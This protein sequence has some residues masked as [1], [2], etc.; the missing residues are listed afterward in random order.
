MSDPGDLVPTTTR[1]RSDFASASVPQYA[2]LG[3][4]AVA[5]VILAL[6]FVNWSTST[7][8]EVVAS[9]LT[10]EQ[11]AE[12]GEQLGSAGIDHRFANGGSAVEVPT[13][14]GDDARV[15]LGDLATP[16]GGVEGYELLDEQGFMI[17]SFRQKIDYQ[18]AVE[19]ELTRT[20]LSMDDVTSAAVHLAV[21][22]QR[23][24]ADEQD[25]TRASV[26]VGGPVT[27]STV[28]S[29]ANVVASAVP[30]LDPANVTVADTSGRILSGGN[31]TGFSR[32]QQLRM[33]EVFEAQLEVAAESMLSVALGPGRA[34]VRV[35]A[36]LD[37]DELES[38]VVTYETE[39]QVTLREQRLDEAF[40]GDNT[41]PLGTLGTAEDVTDAGELAGDSGSAYLRQEVN[42]EFGVPTT[43]TVSRQA[44]GEV[45]R[46]SVAVIV[47][48]TLD[49]PP[50]T[51][52]LEPLVAAAVG[53]DP[54]RGDSIVVQ[55]MAFDEVPEG[56]D[57]PDQLAAG[58]EPGGLEPILGY[59]RT[60][61][62]VIGMILALLFL[63]KGLRTLLPA[64]VREPVEIEP[65]TLA[66]LTASAGEPDAGAAA[67]VEATAVVPAVSP[68]P[69]AEA[70]A[71][72]GS[73]TTIDM[74]DLIDSQSDEVAHL[75]RDLVADT[76]R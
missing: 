41:V 21:P 13:G 7:T 32:D 31:D 57:A 65:A 16:A 28:E 18:R 67:P 23:L 29:I 76:A 14:A 49:P 40:T 5:V 52:A 20:I 27:Q 58:P 35:T 46:I 75:L 26:V 25:L 69:A 62:A 43:R 51:T 59:A 22:E 47:D 10:P 48:Q 56:D 54:E 33:Q 72:P 15:A 37:F 44:P 4:M 24:F 2:A 45:Q 30:G 9:G 6:W 74:L 66:Q 3:L 39:A 38:E 12:V 71:P 73:N 42:S 50:D 19:G 36:D 63:R 68:P 17:S 55:S 61:A 11:A 64:Q 34:V 70:G 1:L 60:G 8:W 53:I